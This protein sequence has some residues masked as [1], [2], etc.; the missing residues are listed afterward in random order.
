MTLNQVIIN[1]NNA[2]F[3]GGGISPPSGGGISNT[4]TLIII[5][6]TVQG[7]M[8]F[9]SAG[10]IYNSNTGVMTIT[11]ST[12]SDNRTGILVTMAGLA[13]EL[14]IMEQ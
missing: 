7:N 3:S 10:G 8:G 12:I 1:N 11:G 2:S 9:L 14:L 5:A 4:G 6:G 13:A